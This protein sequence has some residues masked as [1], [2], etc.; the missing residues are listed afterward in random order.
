[1]IHCLVLMLALQ[2]A[3]N[4][5]PAHEAEGRALLAAGKSEQAAE[6]FR[7]AVVKD[8]E[9]ARLEYELGVALEQGR[10]YGAAI[11][12]LK[13]ALALDA[14]LPGIDDKLGYALLAQGYAAE[15]L[16]HFRSAN[17]VTGQGI[18]ELQTGDLVSAVHHLQMALN[19]SPS[20]ADL[21]YYLARATGLFSKQ[22]YDQLI[23]EHPDT[24]RSRQA[25]AENYAALHQTQQAA[26]LYQA[27]LR[28]RPDLPGVNLALG[29]VYATAN[30]WKQA[31][32]AFR[33]DVK[34]RPGSAESAYRLGS[35]LL[36]EG[37]AHEAREYLARADKLEPN[38]PETLYALGKAASQE[39]DF[40]GAEK[41]WRHQVELEP[42]GELAS[43]AHFGLSALYRKQGKTQ[44][45]VREMKA[46]QATRPGEKQP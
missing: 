19:Q 26:D 11:E 14:G 39:G 42:S 18:A 30:Q 41:A 25:L 20:D 3:G 4:T 9:N 5:L 44:D 40:A 31:E 29:Q 7:K 46:F 12:P 1:M 23:A 8:P 45:A 36:Q 2:A 32:D 21:Q 35:A 15:A 43:Q 38:M 27:A 37:N 34:L 6:E 24:P 33:A 17:D 28:D 13:K 16:P 10:D 22:L